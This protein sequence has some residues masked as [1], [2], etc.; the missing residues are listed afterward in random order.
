M[1]PKG[2]KGYEIGNV[3]AGK[4]LLSGD[5]CIN[6]YEKYATKLVRE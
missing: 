4:I 3:I 1:M 6:E 2:L 5:A